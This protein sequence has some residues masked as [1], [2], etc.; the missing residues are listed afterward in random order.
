MNKIILAT[1]NVLQISSF[2]T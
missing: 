2:K 1:P